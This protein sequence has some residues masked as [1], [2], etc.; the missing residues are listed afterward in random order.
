MRRSIKVYFAP[1]RGAMETKGAKY[2]E[3]EETL[4]PPPRKQEFGLSITSE[5]QLHMRLE[6]LRVL[7][8][9]TM[10]LFPNDQLQNRDGMG[11]QN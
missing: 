4:V 7:A 10:Y 3:F 6:G 8:T 1:E 9:Y 2:V 5:S 11:A